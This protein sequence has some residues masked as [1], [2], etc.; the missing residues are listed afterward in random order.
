[1]RVKVKF[2]QCCPTLCDHMD[3]AVRG[4]LQVRTLQWVAFPS[5]R[6]SS[7]SWDRTQISCIACRFFTSWATKPLLTKLLRL[8]KQL[9]TL[10]LFTKKTMMMLKMV[11]IL[12]QL[13]LVLGTVLLAKLKLYI[14]GKSEMFS[15]RILYLMRCQ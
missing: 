1:M 12:G 9:T 7:Q 5:S 13:Y 15:F 10:W 3:N 6:G 2:T 4:I 8:T 11:S 14:E